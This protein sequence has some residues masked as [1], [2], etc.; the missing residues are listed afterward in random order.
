MSRQQASASFEQFTYV[1]RLISAERKGSL[2]SESSKENVKP[3]EGGLATSNG[4]ACRR[5]GSDGESSARDHEL[6][7]NA[8][9][10]PDGLFHCPWEGQASCN[11]KAE[12]LKCNYE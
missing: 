3:E 6:Y 4:F 5:H 10:G 11:H 1:S 12:K 2:V 7:K 9:P 8:T